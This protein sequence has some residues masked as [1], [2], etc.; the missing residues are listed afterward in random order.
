M[1]INPADDLLPVQESAPFS[2]NVWKLW[3]STPIILNVEYLTLDPWTR[4][5]L[6][7]SPKL[8]Y[9]TMTS[10]E[11]GQA[12]V[13]MNDP[14]MNFNGLLLNPE[15]FFG[16]RPPLLWGV[17][18]VGLYVQGTFNLGEVRSSSPG[19]SG[20]WGS[21]ADLL[22]FGGRARYALSP[23]QIIGLR[24]SFFGEFIKWTDNTSYHRY[25]GFRTY[26]SKVLAFKEFT[27]T[28]THNL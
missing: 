7:I 16:Y 23:F 26:E 27:L 22:E 11:T 19:D 2:T 8:Q 3:I 1:G 13:W 12:W 20:G 4:L 5:V 10:A 28:Y 15:I 9:Q 17:Q 14:G 25:F 24:V 18:E 21:D 6:E